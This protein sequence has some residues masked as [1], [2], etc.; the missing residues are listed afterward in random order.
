MKVDFDKNSLHT[1][2][3]LA[4]PQCFSLLQRT[5]H[6]TPMAKQGSRS[7]LAQAVRPN[8]FP[9]FA[10]EDYKIMIPGHGSS[11]L[12]IIIMQY[13]QYNISYV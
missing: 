3:K 11:Y 2:P 7:A 10:N 6:W 13:C 4:G 12:L 8:Y 5:A 1:A 9:T